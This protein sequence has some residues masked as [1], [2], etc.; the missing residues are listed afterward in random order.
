MKHRMITQRKPL[1]SCL[2]RVCLATLA[3]GVAW[4]LTETT[5]EDLSVVSDG[6]GLITIQFEDV[7]L[8]VFAKFISKVTG[9]NFVFTD[10]ISGTVTVVSPAPVSSDEAY[11]VFQSVL[12]VRGLTTIDDDVV[13]RIIPLKDAR[14]AG[15]EVIFERGGAGFATR[16]LPLDHVNVEE[17]AGVLAAMISK[18]GSVVPYPATNTLIVSDTATNLSRVADIIDALDIPSH[19]QST[20]VIRLSHAAANTTAGQI[21]EILEHDRATRLASKDKASAVP[22][23]TALKIVPDERT[24][25]IIVMGTTLEIGRA[26]ELAESL[27]TALQAGDQRLHVYH[28]RYADAS[29]LVDTV[30][31][32]VA[33]RQRTPGGRAGA[34]GRA[35]GG[36]TL[37]GN[38]EDIAITADDATN[39]VI[40]SASAQEYQTIENL[41]MSLDIERPQV[42]VETI[43]AEVSLRKSEALGFEWQLGGSAGDGTLLARSNLAALGAAAVNPLALSGLVLAAT[44]DKTITL[45]DGTEIPAQTALFTALAEDGEIEV[46]SAPTLL[47]LDNQEAEIIVG[48]NV[49]FI[50]GQ[51]VDLS[52][53]DN[54]FTTVEREDVGI[55]LKIT[56]Q[57]AEGDIIVLQVEEEVSRVINDPVLDANEVGPTTSKRAA[58]TTVSVADGRTAVLGGL[59]INA[60]SGRASKVPL[61]GDIPWI[62]RLFRSEGVTD[63]KVNLILFLTPHV[64][65]NKSDLAAITEQRTRKY[66]QS[67]DDVNEM[68]G[69]RYRDKMDLEEKEQIDVDP[70]KSFPDWPRYERDEL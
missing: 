53:V 29:D 3:L 30:G 54:V 65:R 50:T 49:P 19:K 46:L 47:T 24:N 9:R 23:R 14:T 20:D 51:G 45:P 8:P 33:R 39:S 37:S 55:K 43:I 28:A 58:R 62:G 61:L 48:E 13:T 16:L 26:R 31:S 32:M 12:A 63:E 17:V 5:A 36:A 38:A 22:G 57:V 11:A 42:F 40:I 34:E 70:R 25:S 56:P 6:D 44:S 52:S 59:I 69:D 35:A 15:G 64:I 68:P 41:L 27:D 4:P 18:E 21:T 67:I 1:L 60:V 7:E 66:E 10:K 2:L